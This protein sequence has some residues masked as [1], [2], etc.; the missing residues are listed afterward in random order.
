MFW[1]L[2][3]QHQGDGTIWEVFRPQQHPQME[4]HNDKH[5]TMGVLSARSPFTFHPWHMR[6]QRLDTRQTDVSAWILN[7]PEK[8]SSL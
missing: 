7:C 4:S 2:A 5:V 6:P 8:V 1:E 3:P